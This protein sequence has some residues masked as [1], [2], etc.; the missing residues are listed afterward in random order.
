M[1]DI[2]KSSFLAGNYRAAAKS[3]KGNNCLALCEQAAIYKVGN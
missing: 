3:L 1:P 2:A